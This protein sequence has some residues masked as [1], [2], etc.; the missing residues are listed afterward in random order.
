MASE[1]TREAAPPPWAEGA[2]NRQ[3]ARHT[4]GLQCISTPR[5]AQESAKG[6]NTKP[7]K[8][9]EGRVGKLRSLRSTSSP[10]TLQ[11]P[12]ELQ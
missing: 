1:P 10:V 2:Q 4:P 9:K 8:K 6:A 12:Q 7:W 3:L 11:Y 5:R